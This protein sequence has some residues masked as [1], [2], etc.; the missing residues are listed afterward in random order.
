MEALWVHQYHNVVDL[1]L[2]KHGCSARR[3]STPAPRRRACCATGATA[4]RTRSTCLRK[5]AADP[6]P[7]VRLEAVR[8]ASFF[9]EPEAVEVALISADQ[10]TDEYLD[11][12]RGETM[13]ALEPYVT[14]AI[15]EG[16]DIHFTS[17]A[18]ARYLLKNV[19]TDDLLKMKR[20]QA[21]F[22]E[23]LFRKGVRDEFRTRR[24]NGLAKSGREEA[25]LQC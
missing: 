7:R 21:V 24:M 6:A 19:S 10:P 1:D 17:P 3:T 20:S 15:D 2:L 12:V 14:K 13:R 9:T 18:G 11:Y 8:A 23:L 16:N 22:V 25:R 5:L 4:C